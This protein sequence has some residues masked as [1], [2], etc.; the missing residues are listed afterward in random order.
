MRKTLTKKVPSAT[1]QESCIVRILCLVYCGETP[2]NLHQP[3]FL[4]QAPAVLALGGTS[5]EF[6]GETGDVAN[7]EPEGLLGTRGLRTKFSA[8]FKYFPSHIS[9]LFIEF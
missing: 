3:A 2:V 9:V 7:L 6:V 4:T 5:V 8:S 1:N